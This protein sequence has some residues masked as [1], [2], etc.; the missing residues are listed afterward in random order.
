M[1]FDSSLKENYGWSGEN[2]ILYYSGLTNTLIMP[3]EK[4]Y[5]QIKLSLSGEE[6]GDYINVI[7]AG[8]LKLMETTESGIEENNEE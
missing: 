6:A 5:F 1:S 4:Y 8:D 7:S 2:G 3:D